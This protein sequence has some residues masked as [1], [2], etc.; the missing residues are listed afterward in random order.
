MSDPII[1][2]GR[3]VSSP[4]HLALRPRQAAQALGIGERKL[5]ELTQAGEIPHARLGKAVIYPVS[6]LERWLSDQVKAH[7][8]KSD[9]I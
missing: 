8:G 2:T 9:N 6:A 1:P 4:P 5:W 7:Q 3:F